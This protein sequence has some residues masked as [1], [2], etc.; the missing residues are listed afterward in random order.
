MPVV[1]DLHVEGLFGGGVARGVLGRAA[2]P[3]WCPVAKTVSEAGVQVTG[4]G[5]GSTASLALTSLEKLTV[6]P[7]ASVASATT[8]LLGTVSV[9]AVVSLTVTLK[10]VGVASLPPASVALQVTV[11]SPSGNLAPGAGEQ[12]T[13]TSASTLSVALGLV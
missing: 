4:C 2:R 11:V 6:A 12:S 10:V 5:L 1:L 3:A 7:L 13:V 8:G 9:G